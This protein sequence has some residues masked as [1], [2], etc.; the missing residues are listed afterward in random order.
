MSPK[1]MPARPAD[2]GRNV[3]DLLKAWFEALASQPVPEML[4]RQ[5]DE[6]APKGEEA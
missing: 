2:A 4:L 6:M 1:P 5:L 3:D